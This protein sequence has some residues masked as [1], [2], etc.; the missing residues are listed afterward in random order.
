MLIY[1]KPRTAE[2]PSLQAVLPLYVQEHHIYSKVNARC[3]FFPIAH[4]RTG[5][6][7]CS[8]IAFQWSLCSHC[9]HSCRSPAL[10]MGWRAKAGMQTYFW[11]CLWRGSFARQ[12]RLFIC[13]HKHLPLM[14]KNKVKTR[15]CRIFINRTLQNWSTCLWPIL[16]HDW[17]AFT[18]S[19]WLKI[20]VHTNPTP[21][22]DG[23]QVRKLLT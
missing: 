21:V 1:S 15:N 10:P 9:S 7:N 23:K 8:N 3:P 17:S 6:V 13:Q 20:L 14:V 16:S 22:C 4:R 19:V 5:H 2:V 12:P 18:L 11:Q